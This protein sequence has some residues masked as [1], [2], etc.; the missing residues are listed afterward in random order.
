MRT[1]RGRV[2]S[3]MGTSDDDAKVTHGDSEAE[4]TSVL[5][6]RSALYVVNNDDSGH[7]P[8]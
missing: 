1:D 3:D 4:E 5:I 2:L 8:T 6:T 7:A